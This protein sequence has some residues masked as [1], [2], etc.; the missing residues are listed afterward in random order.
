[1][2]DPTVGVAHP[3]PWSLRS[4]SLLPQYVPA[5][6]ECSVTWCGHDSLPRTGTQVDIIE[7]IQM[8]APK[9]TRPHITCSLN[10]GVF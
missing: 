5:Q 4:P 3:C 10:E 6:R 7:V 9:A 8:G 2:P 1:M